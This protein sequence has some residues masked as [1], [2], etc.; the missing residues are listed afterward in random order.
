MLINNH[1]LHLLIFSYIIQ[2]KLLV[3]KIKFNKE[4]DN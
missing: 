1:D 3:I 2:I 4:N